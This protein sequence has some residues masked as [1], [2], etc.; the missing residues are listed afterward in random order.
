MRSL[1]IGKPYTEGVSRI[2]EGIVFNFNQ[3]GGYLRI[4][5]D[6]PFESE[7]DEIKHG[8][9]KLGLLEEDGIIFFFAKFGSLSWMETPYNVEFSQPYSLEELT[10]E[11][12]GYALQIVLIDGMTG[13]VQAFKLIWFPNEMSKRFKEL[14]EKQLK[15]PVFGYDSALNRIYS[16]YATDDLVTEAEIYSL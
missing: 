6:S 10:D 14:V 9:I 7:I 3:D 2:P 12:A 8:N 16:R 4:A 11:N 15:N 13:I 5:F 1:E